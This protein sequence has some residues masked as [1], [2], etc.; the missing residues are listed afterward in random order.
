MEANVT[1]H[2]L[3]RPPPASEARVR[4]GHEHARGPKLRMPQQLHG[5]TREQVELSGEFDELVASGARTTTLLVGPHGVGKSALLSAL[6]DAAAA[7]GAQVLRAKFD[8]YRDLWGS[9]FVEALTPAG[10]GADQP[11]DGLPVAIE[12]LLLTLC[13][14]GP[15]LLMLDDL[16]H[17][18]P[19]SV[20]LLETLVR[21]AGGPLFI[22]GTLRED[23]LTETH[24]MRGLLDP[25]R[26]RSVPRARVQRV[27]PLAVD[28][29]EDLLGELLG[30]RTRLGRLARIVADKTGGVPLLVSQLLPL[31]VSRGL[32]RAEPGGW[33]WDDAAIEAAPVPDDPVAM[34]RARLETLSADARRLIAHAACLGSRFGLAEVEATE[35]SATRE[36]LAEL[37]EAG[38][39][40]RVG[41]DHSFSFTHDCMRSAARELLAPVEQQGLHWKIG[42]RLLA[43]L[44]GPAL[45]EHLFEIV[46]HLAAGL[47]DELDASARIEIAALNLRAGRRAADSA[48]HNLA[49]RYL[50]NGMEVLGDLAG[51]ELGFDLAREHA[52][53]LQLTKHGLLAEAAFDELLARSAA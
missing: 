10:L 33:A 48:A 14:D 4:R 32:M 52:R 42:R 7:H 38:L 8:P 9:A 39:L 43:T 11:R 45:D 26:Q 21:G 53:A 23:E 40:L 37:V 35:P 13:A 50:C 6:D 3:P 34:L 15:V 2:P 17:A 49:L 29:I 19:R 31:L 28:A 30:A 36:R 46:E 41:R 25:I 18:D 51:S 24:P 1:S 27:E 44:D 12:R 47:P 22:A 20:A 5:R 16:H